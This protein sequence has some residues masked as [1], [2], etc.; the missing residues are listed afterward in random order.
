[1][2]RKGNKEAHKNQIIESLRSHGIDI[3]QRK[4]TYLFAK[5]PIDEGYFIVDGNLNYAAYDG[6]VEE[7]KKNSLKP[8][9]HV[10]GNYE[11]Y[12]DKKNIAFHRLSET[13]REIATS[14]EEKRGT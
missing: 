13:L 1:M 2:G 11:T 8:P 6:I 14:E 4:G 12:Q 5:G 7:A 9:Y 3:T 10:Y